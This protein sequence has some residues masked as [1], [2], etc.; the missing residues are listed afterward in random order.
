MTKQFSFPAGASAPI[1]AF[2]PKSRRA[3]FLARIFTPVL[4]ALH[5]ARRI[6]AQRVLRVHRHLLG[7]GRNIGLPP[8]TEAMTMSIADRSSSRRRYVKI[9]RPSENVL[10][11]II[12]GAILVF[13]IVGGVMVQRALP[14]KPVAQLDQALASYGD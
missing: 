8:S 14:D 2:G 4:A 6:Q 13:H 3:G 10:L 1:A 9:P 5:H 7:S 12:A 11:T